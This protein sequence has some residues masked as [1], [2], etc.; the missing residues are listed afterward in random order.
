MLNKINNL[1]NYTL[2]EQKSKI[3][4][5]NS[6]THT[7]KRIL[8]RVYFWEKT[9]YYKACFE[10]QITIAKKLGISK[11]TISKAFKKFRELGLIEN[12]K[13][14]KRRFK[15]LTP[16]GYEVYKAM[17]ERNKGDEID[18]LLKKISQ[19]PKEPEKEFETRIIGEIDG[20]PLY[21][22]SFK[23]TKEREE[24]EKKEKIKL[25]F[26]RDELRKILS[27]DP[28]KKIYFPDKKISAFWFSH[29]GL[30]YLTYTNEEDLKPNI[31]LV[32]DKRQ[33]FGYSYCMD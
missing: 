20:Q 31:I 1:D 8:A 14:G 2:K 16:L 18:R 28:R 9:G 7:E 26:T 5:L 11:G 10:K 4:I 21:E 22:I 3:E 17:I 6:L 13:K 12:T 27:K 23:P 33:I 24:T 32:G 25:P 15:L 29:D 30:I 19:Q